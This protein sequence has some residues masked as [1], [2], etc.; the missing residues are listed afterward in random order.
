MSKANVEFFLQESWE[1]D[2]TFLSRKN[3]LNTSPFL[4]LHSLLIN[5]LFS[6]N[7]C[8]KEKLEM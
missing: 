5:L 3:G 2:T 8:R 6:L 4:P 1:I 7:F